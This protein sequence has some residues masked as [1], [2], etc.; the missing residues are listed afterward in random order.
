M[1]IIKKQTH[2][3]THSNGQTQKKIENLNKSEKKDTNY[4]C[5]YTT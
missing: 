5:A 4:I 2:T 3:H 1:S